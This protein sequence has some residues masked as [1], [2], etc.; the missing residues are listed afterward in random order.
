MRLAK[1]ERGKKQEIVWGIRSVQ[2]APEISGLISMG[3][4]KHGASRTEREKCEP[5]FFLRLTDMMFV[6]RFFL[7]SSLRAMDFL[8]FS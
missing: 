6:P 3:M 1:G 4:R 7:S 5:L 2:D 8:S